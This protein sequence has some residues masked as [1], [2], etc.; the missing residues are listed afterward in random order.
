[1][2]DQEFNMM[3]GLIERLIDDVTRLKKAEILL[4][5]KVSALQDVATSTMAGLKGLSFEEADKLVRKAVAEK[6][7]ATILM[8][9]ETSPEFAEKIDLHPNRTGEWASD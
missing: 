6:Y 5:S 7:E 8:I 1:M 4:R 9:G 2:T 3:A